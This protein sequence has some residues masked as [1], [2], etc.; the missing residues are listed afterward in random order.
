MSLL[1]SSCAIRVAN[2]PEVCDEKKKRKKK[3]KIQ[4][5]SSQML[6]NVQERME[7]SNDCVL[8]R[9]E[10]GFV[11]PG[12]RV[13]LEGLAGGLTD[14]AGG[15]LWGLMVGIYSSLFGGV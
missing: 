15:G 3:T 10:S 9:V 11:R 12:W 2:V 5:E 8:R 1:T 13:G 4:A 14:G 6:R 7:V